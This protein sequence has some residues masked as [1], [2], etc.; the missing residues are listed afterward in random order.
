MLKYPKS[1]WNIIIL[2]VLEGDIK[3]DILKEKEQF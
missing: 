2:E 3:L 1:N